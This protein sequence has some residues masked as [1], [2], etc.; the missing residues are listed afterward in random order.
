MP[1]LRLFVTDK[2]FSTPRFFLAGVAFILSAHMLFCSAIVSAA[3]VTI[4]WD[5]NTEYDLAGYKI[6]Y[7]TESSGPGYDGVGVTEGDSPIL[8]PLGYLNNPTSPEYTLHGLS[9][10]A[11]TSLVVTAYDHYGTE[12]GYSNE[13]SY[14]PDVDRDGIADWWE[15]RYFEHL[16]R[17]GVG[18]WD[19]DG[20]IDLAEFEYGTDPTDHDSDSDHFRDGDELATDTDPSDP[21]SYPAYTGVFFMSPPLDLPEDC[22]KIHVEYLQW[23]SHD[24]EP[25]AADIGH[26]LIQTYGEIDWLSWEYLETVTTSSGGWSPTQIDLSAYAGL[27]VRLWFYDRDYVSTGSGQTDGWYIPEVEVICTEPSDKIMVFRQLPDEQYRLLLYDAPSAVG[28]DAGPVI[29]SDNHIGHNIVAGDCA[30]FDSDPE[31]ELVVVRRRSDGMADLQIY[32]LPTTVGGNTGPPLASYDQIGADITAIAGVDFDS[33]PE[34]ELVVLRRRLSGAYWLQIYDVPTA[35]GGGVGQPLASDGYLAKDVTTIAGV[36]F[37]SDPEDELV[38]VRRHPNGAYWLQIYDLP[39]TTEGDT[40]PPLASGSFSA[41]DVIEYGVAAGNFDGD[42]EDELVVVRPLNNGVDRLQ[43]YDM[44]TRVGGDMGPLIAS[45]AFF[46][47]DISAV[48]VTR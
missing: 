43:I 7:R 14:A 3:D 34:D 31:D 28:G 4:A 33:D 5:A 9:D 48:S 35:T 41:N 17:D 2:G 16:D 47:K 23:F 32:D 12:S 37:D 39:T 46:V 25:K 10:T 22:G 30:N 36:D 13:V 6:H 26:V 8:V 19:N 24:S 18:D 27:R 40:G 42:P 15:L 29:A 1:H 38:V 45:D 20:L 11:T 44:P 21:Q